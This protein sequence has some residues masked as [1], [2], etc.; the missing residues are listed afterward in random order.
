[1]SNKVDYIIVGQG[2]AGTVLAIKLLSRGKKVI[3]FDEETDSSSSKVALGMVNPVTG[4]KL[5][6]SWKV[7][8]LLP[9]AISFYKKVE[10]LFNV[11]LL[12]F[13]DIIRLFSSSKDINEW[14][15]RQSDE[16][17]GDYLSDVC[18]IK[19]D[20][21]NAEHGG[22]IKRGFW[23]DIPKMLQLFKSLYQTSIVNEVFNHDEVVFLDN[24]VKY[25]NF[26]TNR[27]VFCDGYKGAENPFF[28]M[29][30]FNLSKG[31]ILTIKSDF[32]FDKILNK[33]GSLVP[34]NDDEY[35]IG[36]TFVW[37]DLSKVVTL[38]GREHLEHKLSS[39]INCSYSVLKQEVG[40][41]PTVKDRRPFIGV[42]PN[43]NQLCI[44][45]GLGTKG[46]SLAPY[47]AGHLVEFLEMGG[48][49]DAEVCISRFFK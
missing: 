15:L 20:E 24:N 18:E 2:L 33:G 27:V 6:K 48:S 16:N 12:H 49:L 42:H 29:L 28:K 19:E 5:V 41:R 17:Y 44:F 1:M 35:K 39:M 4:R 45:N 37:D 30:P 36:G 10:K 3:V 9:E 31:E 40:I 23:L 13:T 11:E 21:I 32:S 43:Y 14:Q 26:E 25:K 22:I 34:V 47:Y 38:K 8:T 46:V 7:D